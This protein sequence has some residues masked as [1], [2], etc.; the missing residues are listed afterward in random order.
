MEN[1]IQIFGS[2]S[3]GYREGPFSTSNVGSWVSSPIAIQWPV[4]SSAAERNAV[5]LGSCKWPTVFFSVLT[6]SA[7]NT[8]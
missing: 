7:F 2:Q 4:E 6:Y 8:R 3:G 5:Y 1:P